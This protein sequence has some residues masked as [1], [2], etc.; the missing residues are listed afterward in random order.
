MELIITSIA[1]GVLIFFIIYKW[2]NI[3]IKLQFNIDK[4]NHMSNAEPEENHIQK[5]SERPQKELG[6]NKWLYPTDNFGKM[7]KGKVI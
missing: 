7:E 6:K 1:L 5:S 2:T 3:K 4:K